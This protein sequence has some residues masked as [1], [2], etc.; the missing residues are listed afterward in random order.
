MKI[1]VVFFGGYLAHQHAM[2]LWLASATNR[3][4][5]VFDA[6]HYPDGAGYD[7]DD[8]VNGFKQFDAV[9]KK[10]KD[11]GA[12]MTYIVGHSSGCAIA[13]KVD[14]LLTKG[15]KDTSHIS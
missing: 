5:V 6:F 4:D 12:D 14:L 1:Y 9:V 3:K 8:A 2:D 11:T 13:N 15:M 10:I 7:D